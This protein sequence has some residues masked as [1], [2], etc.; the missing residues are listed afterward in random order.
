MF[1]TAKPYSSFC[2]S[3]EK[4]TL[5]SSSD[6]IEALKFIDWMAF[7]DILASDCHC[8]LCGKEWC[9]MTNWECIFFRFSIW[10]FFLTSSNILKM[11]I[12]QSE[13]ST[14]LS[15]ISSRKLVYVIYKYLRI[16]IICESLVA[17]LDCSLE[18]NH[19]RHSYLCFTYKLSFP[20][21]NDPIDW[22][23]LL[24]THDR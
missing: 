14:V 16:H 1:P 10:Q 23:I 19:H 3:K 17:V 9:Q 11:S 2:H 12:F 18:M 5:S 7:I 13:C 22:F 4:N 6:P 15:I 20:M 24:S 21:W 8:D